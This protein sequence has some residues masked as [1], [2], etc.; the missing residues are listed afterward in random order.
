MKLSKGSLVKV[1][2]KFGQVVDRIDDFFEVCF[3]DTNRSEIVTADKITILES[4]MSKTLKGVSPPTPE[5]LKKIA[6]F[7]P[8]NAPEIEA[9]EISI[10]TIVAADNM[11]DRSLARWNPVDLEQL[12]KLPVGFPCLVDHDAEVENINGVV[13]ESGLLRFQT[14]PTYFTNTANNNAYNRQI[15]KDE[16]YV[17][18]ILRIALEADS[19]LVESLNLGVGW[20]SLGYSYQDVFCPL[21]N[22]SFY[23]AKCPHGIPM[24]KSDQEDPR[25]APWREKKFPSDIYEVSFVAEPNLP[26]AGIVRNLH[27]TLS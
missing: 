18:F 21:C 12:T 8:I 19:D 15:A 26:R 7:Q 5:D 13:F 16:G 24:S 14:V 1:G 10:V 23:D 3:D 27:K 11:L 25:Y 4:T 6:L 20:V 9:G 22:K 17:A 2:D